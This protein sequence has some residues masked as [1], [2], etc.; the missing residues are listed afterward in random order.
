MKKIQQ[1]FSNARNGLFGPRDSKAS[2]LALAARAGRAGAK[3]GAVEQ[4][5]MEPL[6]KREYLF[7]LTVDAADPSFVQDP[8]RPHYGTVTANFAY[9]MPFLQS[10]LPS[11][12]AFNFVAGGVGDPTSPGPGFPLPA[13]SPLPDGTT[14]PTPNP[15]PRTFD[16]VALARNRMAAWL[17]AHMLGVQIT[18]Y[19][20]FEDDPNTAAV[21]VPTSIQVFDLYGRD[22]QQ[23]LD[24]GR[25]SP[26]LGPVD[27]G[28]D[29]GRPALPA[30][31][32]GVPPAVP[33]IPAANHDQVNPDDVEA[34]GDRGN[35]DGTL[36][37]FN[38]LGIAANIGDGVPDM[39]DGLGMIVLIQSDALTRMNMVGGTVVRPADAATFNALDIRDN[40]TRYGIDIPDNAGMR[41]AWDTGGF[42]FDII[43]GATPNISGLPEIAGSVLFGAPF[44]REN[45]DSTSY[46]GVDNNAPRTTTPQSSRA[47]QVADLNFISQPLF[48]GGLTIDGVDINVPIVGIR[49]LRPDQAVGEIN[50][51]GLVMGA[52]NVSGSLGLF[53]AQHMLGSLSVH[54]DAGQVYVGGTMGYWVREDQRGSGTAL[55]NLH[56]TG[57]ALSVGGRLGQF[58]VAGRNRANVFVGGDTTNPRQ[59]V[60]GSTYSEIET[61]FGINPANPVDSLAGLLN[62]GVIRA[63][64]GTYRNDDFSTAEFIY[65]GLPGTTISG[66]LG[67]ADPLN[68]AFDLTDVYAFA[69]D[70]GHTVQ[71]NALFGG[72]QNPDFG[73]VRIYDQNHNLVATHQIDGGNPAEA[74]NPAVPPPAGVNFSFV[75]PSSG[76][77]YMVIGTLDDGQFATQ[78]A[79]T[80]TIAGQAATTLGQIVTGGG[81][82]DFTLQV[83]SGAVGRIS[84]GFG[85]VSPTNAA[86][87]RAD[88]DLSG[89][90]NGD[91]FDSFDFDFTVPNMYDLEFGSDVGPGPAGGSFLSSFGNIGDIN[92][93]G[94]F[95]GIGMTV[96]GSLGS[97]DVAGQTGVQPNGIVRRTGGTTGPVAISTGSFA[98]PGNIGRLHFG[99]LVRGD[100]FSLTTS[101]NSFVD[102]MEALGGFTTSQ[103]TFNLGQGSDIRFATFNQIDIA[104]PGQQPII[105]HFLPLTPNTVLSL[106]DDS[107]VT[108]TIRITGAGSF[109]TVR[110]APAN[111]LGGVVLGSINIALA[112]GGSV[113]ISTTSA[114]SLAIGQVNVT[115]GSAASTVNFTGPAEIDVRELNIN[116][117]VRSINN[118]TPDGDL[119]SVDVLGV[120]SVTVNG[121][122][123][124]S[125]TY[126]LSNDDLALHSNFID[127]VLQQV[128]GLPV[129]I[130]NG[131]INNWLGALQTIPLNW[132]TRAAAEFTLEDSGSPLDYVRNGIT[133]RTG[134][135]NLISARG[136]IGDVILQGGLGGPGGGTLTSVIPNSD[137]VNTTGRF[138]GI[139]GSIYAGEITN[140]DVGDGVLSLTDSPFAR[141]GIFALDDIINLTAGQR[142]HDPVLNHIAIVAGNSVPGDNANGIGTV[143]IT[144]ADLIASYVHVGNLDSWWV[145][146]RIGEADGI[147]DSGNITNFLVTGGDVRLT[148]FFAS[149]IT[150]ISITGGVWDSNSAQ[151]TFSIGTISADAFMSSL[152]NRDPLNYSFNQIRA[153]FDAGT[154][155]TTN[156]AVGDIE[157]LFIGAGRSNT[158][159]SAH[160]V[161]R[162]N[163]DIRGNAGTMTFSGDVRASSIG[164]GRLS[165]MAVHGD[166][167]SSSIRISGAILSLTAGG[168][169]LDTE[170][171]SS[172]PDGRINNLTAGGTMT[173]SVTSSGPI[174]TIRTTRGD[175]ILTVSTTDSTDGNITTIQAGRDL[176]LNLGM[177]EGANVNALR[178][179]RNI[180]RRL[181]DGTTPDLLDIHGNITTITAGGVLYSDVRA[182]GTIGTVT[183][184]RALAYL[185]GGDYAT[186]AVITSSSRINTVNINGDFNGSII[187]YSGGIGSV[188]ITNGSFRAG[189]AQRANRIEARDGDI[190][191]VRIV[192]GH[193]LGDILAPQGSITTISVTGDAVFGD[194]GINPDLSSATQTGVPIA[195]RRPQIPVGATL[196]A[197]RDGP[198]I[199]AGI[200]IGTIT[201]T[202]GIFEATISAGRTITSITVGRG[203]D[204]A[205]AA[206]SADD[207]TAIIAGDAITRMTVGQLARGTFIESGV[208]SLGADAQPGGINANADSVKSGTIG[209]LTFRG[210]TDTV[211]VAAGL[212]AGTDG[213]FNT[214]DDLVAPGVSTITSVQ[215]IGTATN[216]IL[217]TDS[218]TPNVSAN[219][220]GGSNSVIAGAGTIG[221]ADGFA[222]EGVIPGGSVAVT[223]AGIIVSIGGQLRRV[224]FTGA[225]TATYSA[226]LNAGLGAGTLVLAGTTTAST[227]RID[228]AP[229]GSVSIGTLRAI[230]GRDDASLGTLNATVDISTLS[231]TIDA[232]IN[233]VTTRNLVNSPIAAGQ[234][235]GTV[236]AGVTGSNTQLVVESRGAI[237]T[238]RTLGGV[239]AGLVS[240]SI[241]GLTIGT[242]RIGGQLQGSVSS[243]RDI[244]SATVTGQV[245]SGSG[246]R[247]GYNMGATTVGSMDTSAISAGG[248][249]TSVRV[250]GNVIDSSILAGVDLGQDANFGG[251]GVNA[252][253][254]TNGNM[255]TVTIQGNFIRSDIGAGV[256]QGPDGFVGTPDDLLGEG[257]SS[258]GNV[259]ITGSA[260][261][262]IFNTEQYRIA[263]NGTIGTVR[264]GGLPFS[265]AAN[266]QVA[267]DK[268]A[269]APLTVTNVNVEFIGGVYFATIV[270]NQSVSPGTLAGALSIAE[271][272]GPEPIATTIPLVQGTDYTVTYV[273]GSN[274]ALIQF[275]Q[276]VTDR[277]LNVGVNNHATQ[278]ALAGAG[279][280]RFNLNSSVIRG[281]TAATRLDGDRDGVAESTDSWTGDFVVGDAGDRLAISTG[282]A[283]DSSVID[284]FAP[285]NLDVVMGSTNVANSPDL[286]T[287]FNIQ[288]Y[289][290]DHPD[291][292]VT[293]FEAG[294]DIDIYSITLTA[295]QVIGAGI[296]AGGASVQVFN[297]VLVGGRPAL[298]QTT[299]QTLADGRQMALASGTYFL[300]VSSTALDPFLAAGNV[301]VPQ[302]I[303]GPSANPINERGDVVNIPN[304][305]L[306]GPY[307]LSVRISDDGDNGFEGPTDSSNG[308]NVESAP[309]PAA[310]AGGDSVLGTQDDLASITVGAYVYHLEPGANNTLNG[311]GTAGHASDDRVVGVNAFGTEQVR[312]AGGDGV[313]GTADDITSINDAIGERNGVGSNLVIA[314]DVDIFHLNAGAPIVAGQ[315]YRFT[316]RVSEWGGDLGNLHTPRPLPGGGVGVTG[317]DMRGQAQF[318]LFET[319]ATGGINGGSLVAQAPNP[320]AF[321]AVPNTVVATDGS[322][323]YGYDANGDFYM[324]I[325]MPPSQADGTVDATFALYVQGAHQSNYTVDIQNIG[326]G[327]EASAQS[328]NFLI[329]TNGG[330]VSWLEAFGPT[331]LERYSGWMNA[332]IPGL[333]MTTRAYVLS[334]LLNNLNAIFTAA[335]VN[336]TI[337]TSSTDFVGQTFSTVFLTDS[338]ETADQINQGFFGVSQRRDVL[339][340]DRSDQAVVFAPA[341]TE[342]NNTPDQA[343][344]DSYVTSLTAAVAQRMGELLGLT[345]A[346][347]DTGAAMVN[348][349]P[350]A[351]N[352]AGL[353]AADVGF[354]TVNTGLDQNLRSSF[355][356]GQQNDTQLLRR[357]F[358]L[359]T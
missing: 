54:D 161:I 313:F 139:T 261:G 29:T 317:D 25:P 314:S 293:F 330:T 6:E 171:V 114:G 166:I 174:T 107:G 77:Y 245:T 319:D 37:P 275:S 258:L 341:M 327:P 212:I 271:V 352:A 198:I 284:F 93:A 144:N 44:I 221:V 157:D 303:T 135:V 332:A 169:I 68:T 9:F 100:Q 81:L 342:L 141:A 1:L 194:I 208:T 270:F 178:A 243:Q 209:T 220:T 128:V 347:F 237:G 266:L 36:T 117:V 338:L 39:N 22:M 259:T 308:S 57:G 13:G 200:N 199:A 242:V 118:T 230:V 42:G 173:G 12:S 280:F 72:N 85:V 340:A 290:G 345:F 192:R 124:A 105:D 63:G 201:T 89:T 325:T 310:F 112:P 11:I 312:S 309:L 147:Q 279:V 311:N 232:S 299:L 294:S 324:E 241:R 168:D 339:N 179:G 35:I 158:N 238:V 262:S 236:T 285:V 159:I 307:T 176:V 167:H 318:A 17:E 356:L 170:I 86:G 315:R 69:A 350:G 273:P 204:N 337:S 66:S 202:G 101:A 7:V 274:S 84:G 83:N 120:S 24:I 148:D 253:V 108:F 113:F 227:I 207:A 283:A 75:A 78:M 131:L 140:V 150:R 252:D 193:L 336:V 125:R 30:G 278:S 58:F 297:Q 234:S 149:N 267:G 55:D 346:G 21:E 111:A 88:S 5:L 268:A 27:L 272:R 2:T 146:Q 229:A 231:T 151:A 91:Y 162:S 152:S 215:V 164:S 281:Q 326:T 306:T 156:P 359:T 282:L 247:A 257:R 187:S 286:N 126:V 255:G 349:A 134:N 225:G 180:G 165:S 251:S 196:T 20:R 133:I 181:A 203:I 40:N 119:V 70:A 355:I 74:T 226:A 298:V 316:L 104:N 14:V 264:A 276:D 344:I 71:L 92:V 123:G 320:E 182:S 95:L 222:F 250:N 254:V 121:S 216:T 67:L 288:G 218:G 129:G 289:M 343:G 132:S 191:S 4:S 102:V 197:G 172:G 240:S 16:I 103:P 291:T 322:T 138:E 76:V 188:T 357:I 185:A 302:V 122:I 50:I 335:G 33:A 106:T 358:Q 47:A 301:T 59:R 287:T 38:R 99:G 217:R 61:V 154:V 41:A 205:A 189:D 184:G 65:S 163:I 305:A 10:Q 97:L 228:A 28:P 110:T 73:L 137:R 210:G 87:F 49:T 60:E 334:Q 34:I 183:S 96:G 304:N 211:T 127:G 296:T 32:G 53:Y 116:G 353:T 115:G 145:S 277:S 15:D 248:N 206:P 51:P 269:P 26:L 19:G 246:I 48:S 109:G 31:P 143:R 260:Q 62:S 136:S 213:L 82:S 155:R 223:S 175:I 160:N 351:V 214:V 292:A 23:R 45:F 46:F 295:G 348:T 263:S 3:G 233:T 52:I 186:D 249:I 321:H 333:G 142:V 8:N 235:M 94:N 98:V 331:R 130:P 354:N 239:S 90:T 195:E 79:Y 64:L 224:T 153:G 80:V 256:Y 190:T 328:Q 43:P 177:A 300:V 329:E 219:L 18:L 265:G 56:A 323:T 244:T